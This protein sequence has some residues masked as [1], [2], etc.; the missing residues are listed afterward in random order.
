MRVAFLGLCVSAVA[1]GCAA[2]PDPAA[3]AA[4][5]PDPAPAPRAVDRN[6]ARDLKLVASF[7]HKHAHTNRWPDV[8]L[9]LVNTSA[10]VTYPV[11]KPIAGCEFGQYEPHLSFAAEQRSFKGKWEPLPP[12]GGPGCGLYGLGGKQEVVELKPG[13]KL[14]LTPDGFHGHFY[15]PRD[16]GRMRMTATYEYLRP[17][18]PRAPGG[19]GAAGPVPRAPLPEMRGS[20]PFKLV[21]NTVE[22]DVVMP[23]HLAV[24]A[25]RALK[26]GETAKLSELLE[27]TLTNTTG[28]RARLHHLGD[29]ELS[30]VAVN[31]NSPELVTARRIAFPPPPKVEGPFGRAPRTDADVMLELNDTVSLLGAG[32]MANGADAEWTGRAKG[33]FPLCVEFA[34]RDWNHGEKLFAFVEFTVE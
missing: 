3:P 20:P 10:T 13:A 33:T 23:L 21:S 19:P 31:V 4:V 5:P 29:A 1:I 32:Q 11:P 12:G 8:T 15:S 2:K 25:K 16:T 34:S 27:I 7:D 28:D 22:F 18:D 17:V 9:A 14:V 6:P 24:R 26:V 30:H